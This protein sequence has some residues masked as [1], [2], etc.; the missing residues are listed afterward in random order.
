MYQPNP[1]YL[2]DIPAVSLVENPSAAII[3]VGDVVAD[4]ILGLEELFGPLSGH[5]ADYH[6]PLKVNL[7]KRLMMNNR[8]THT[9]TQTYVPESSW[10]PDL[11]S[12]HCIDP[13]CSVWQGGAPSILQIWIYS[14]QYFVSI[15][16]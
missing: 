4:N 14:S 12:M 7:W 9:H 1:P 11:C 3:A 10:S 16:R 13:D 5:L 15:Q 2:S 8:H 6:W